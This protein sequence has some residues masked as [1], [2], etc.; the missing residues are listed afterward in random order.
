M[1]SLCAMA[2]T[3]T[4]KT[5]KFPQANESGSHL[6]KPLKQIQNEHNEIDVDDDY[7]VMGEAWFM[8]VGQFLFD[9]SMY[10]WVD[11]KRERN[12]SRLWE[13]CEYGTH[14]TVSSQCT[15]TIAFKTKDADE[16]FLI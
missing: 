12:S 16:V 1:E 9:C 11:I 13:K 4:A 10:L 15:R 5:V 2:H 3:P 14:H 8:I 7:V 6:M